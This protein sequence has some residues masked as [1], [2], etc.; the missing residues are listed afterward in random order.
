MQICLFSKKLAERQTQLG[1]LTLA[2]FGQV[3]KQTRNKQTYNTTWS[4]CLLIGPD[5]NVRNS[6]NP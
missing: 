6:L 2:Q 5:E 1:R 3:P 4:N